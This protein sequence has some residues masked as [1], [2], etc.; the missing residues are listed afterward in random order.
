MIFG[1]YLRRR[2]ERSEFNK[3]ILARIRDVENENRREY[4]I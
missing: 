3:S 2:G 1:V 4:C